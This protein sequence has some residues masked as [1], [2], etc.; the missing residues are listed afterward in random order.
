MWAKV[1]LIVTLE[2]AAHS[3]APCVARRLPKGVSTCVVHGEEGKAAALLVEQL[4]NMDR[5]AI[6]DVLEQLQHT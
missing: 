5:E 3:L 1:W 6:E 2:E 4:H